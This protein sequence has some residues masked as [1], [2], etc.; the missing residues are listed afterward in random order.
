MIKILTQLHLA[1]AFVNAN[2]TY[3]DSAKYMYKKMEDSILTAQGTNLAIF[4]SSMSY[5]QKDVKSMDE[6]YAA[7]IDSLSLMEGIAK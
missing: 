1:E 6:I 3:S 2:Y 7:S 5:Y 4:D